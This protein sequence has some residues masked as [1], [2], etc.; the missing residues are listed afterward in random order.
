M[1][2]MNVYTNQ[3]WKFL[4]KE[5][6][7]SPT[8]DFMQDMKVTEILD[9]GY[10]EALANEKIQAEVNESFGMFRIEKYMLFVHME[11]EV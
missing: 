8:A 7:E 3:S 2:N 4:E 9:Y 1:E 10:K 6:T 5:E 11:G